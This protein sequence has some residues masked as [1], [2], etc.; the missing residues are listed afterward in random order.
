MSR[1]VPSKL[2]AAAKDSRQASHW[3]KCQFVTFDPR[4]HSLQKMQM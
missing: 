3:P 2:Q 4:K 1:E